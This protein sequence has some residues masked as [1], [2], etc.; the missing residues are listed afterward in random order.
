MTG[1]SFDIIADVAFAP[2][3]EGGRREPTPRETFS[4]IMEIDGEFFSCRLLLDEIGSI[5]PGEQVTVP[6]QFLFPDLVRPKLS[7]G[8]TFYL[9][10]IGRIAS[11]RIKR[12]S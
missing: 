10:E 12:I 6:I 7:V 3:S 5:S 1:T 8:K 4:C 2:T 9:N 11:G